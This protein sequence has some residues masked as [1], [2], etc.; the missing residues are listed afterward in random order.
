MRRYFSLS[1]PELDTAGLQMTTRG[2]GP[3]R[4]LWTIFSVERPLMVQGMVLQA[5]QAA[6][7]WGLI[8]TAV[9]SH[10][11]AWQAKRLNAPAPKPSCT[12]C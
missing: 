1:Q 5:L 11:K 8:S 3:L 12:A 2:L 6:T 10:F 4:R 7:T 9:V